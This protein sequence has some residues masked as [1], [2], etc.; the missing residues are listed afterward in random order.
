MRKPITCSVVFL[1]CL[2]CIIPR[3]LSTNPRFSMLALSLE[4]ATTDDAKILKR[5]RFLN[6]LNALSQSYAHRLLTMPAVLAAH[7]VTLATIA[8]N[9]V[10]STD[11]ISHDKNDENAAIWIN[12]LKISAIKCQNLAHYMLGTK[13][14]APENLIGRADSYGP[15]TNPTIMQCI[16]V[17]R[18]LQ[19]TAIVTNFKATTFLGLSRPSTNKFKDIIDCKKIALQ[20]H[21]RYHNCLHIPMYEIFKWKATKISAKNHQLIRNRI[22][23][24]LAIMWSDFKNPVNRYVMKSVS[25]ECVCMLNMIFRKFKLDSTISTC[26][27]S[28]FEH[29]VG[30]DSPI[31]LA[32]TPTE[33]LSNVSLPIY[34]SAPTMLVYNSSLNR[35]GGIFDWFLLYQE[36]NIEPV[37]DDLIDYSKLGDHY[38]EGLLSSEKL[39]KQFQEFIRVHVL[40]KI[41]EV[42]DII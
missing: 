8:R 18:E 4:T 32:H 7:H 17:H 6:Q 2:F 19:S 38:I 29:L 16:F 30:I 22:L 27:V 9:I 36:N 42:T 12:N 15:T 23:Y 39:I 20:V 10:L 11:V 34:T 26:L 35:N 33:F 41:E 28:P 21:Q 1:T 13:T 14:Y 25:T 5:N 31:A 3:V 24:F 40:P 37:L